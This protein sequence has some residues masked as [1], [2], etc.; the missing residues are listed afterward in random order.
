[1]A[2][3]LSL[4]IAVALVGLL[5]VTGVVS[6]ATSSVDSPEQG[7]GFEL[8]GPPNSTRVFG[9]STLIQ[10]PLRVDGVVL[11]DRTGG[12]VGLRGVAVQMVPYYADATSG[13]RDGFLAQVTQR[14]FAQR[15]QEFARMGG[16]GYNT[17]RLHIPGPALYASELYETRSQSLN[18]IVAVIRSAKTHGLMT[19]LDA[20]AVGND[21]ANWIDYKPLFA[22]LVASIGNDPFVIWEPFNEP[23]DYAGGSPRY[24]AALKGVGTYLRALGSTQPLILPCNKYQQRVSPIQM[25]EILADA[26]AYGWRASGVLFGVHPYLDHFVSRPDYPGDTFTGALFDSLERGIAGH[27]RS[28]PL[29]VTEMGRYNNAITLTGATRA[30]YRWIGA[31]GARGLNG[32]IAWSWDWGLGREASDPNA[33]TWDGLTLNPWGQQSH[34]EALSKMSFPELSAGQPPNAGANDARIG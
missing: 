8:A 20:D 1:M 33:W 32:F 18:R 9:P 34:D 14:N 12:R 27:L 5:T 23:A 28:Y 17:I 21:L 2:R 29:I 19:I 10:P 31:L 22:D 16:L 24:L 7:A 6:A 3:Q 4:V 30:A 26:D 11:R 15:D 25:D 13:A